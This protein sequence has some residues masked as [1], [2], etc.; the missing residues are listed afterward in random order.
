[1]KA[2]NHELSAHARPA[3]TRPWGGISEDHARQKYRR[4]RLGLPSDLDGWL[5]SALSIPDSDADDNAKAVSRGMARCL[6]WVEVVKVSD[7]AFCLYV[8]G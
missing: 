3:N 5:S 4:E 7:T 1:M 8:L 2:A 6:L